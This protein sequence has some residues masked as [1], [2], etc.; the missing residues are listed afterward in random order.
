MTNGPQNLSHIAQIILSP[1][2]SPGDLFAACK[3]LKQ[4]LSNLTSHTEDLPAAPQGIQT[5]SGLALG[6]DWAIKCIE[7]IYRTKFYSLGLKDAIQ[8]KIALPW[9]GRERTLCRLWSFCHLNAA[10]NFRN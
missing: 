3:N 5:K 7:D 10:F 1:S 8:D 4:L 2:T 9:Q 6:T